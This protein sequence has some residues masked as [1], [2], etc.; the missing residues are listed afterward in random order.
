[1]AVET[2]TASVLPFLR[3]V[4]SAAPAETDLEQSGYPRSCPGSER[5]A[6]QETEEESCGNTPRIDRIMPRLSSMRYEENSHNKTQE[7]AQKRDESHSY[8]IQDRQP[9]KAHE[10]V[11]GIDRQQQSDQDLA[12]QEQGA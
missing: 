12:Y 11:G 6:Q 2:I 3:S 4:R 10:N 1:M 9:T 7:S 8:A 5:K